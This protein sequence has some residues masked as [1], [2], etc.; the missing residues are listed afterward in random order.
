MLVQDGLVQVFPKVG[1]FV[2]RV[3]EQSV[4]DAQFLREAVE[5]ASLDDVPATPDPVVVAELR[6]ILAEQ[7]ACED[8]PEAFFHLD[9]QF[10]QGLLR[11]AHHEGT[12]PPVVAAKAH[13]DRA[14]RLGLQGHS[15]HTF[16]SQH[17]EILDSLLE[18]GA[19]SARPILRDHLR[20]VLQDIA[21]I[22]ETSPELFAPTSGPPV[23][24]NVAVWE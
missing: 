24:R 21:R 23:R 9:E 11:L 8:D 19:D 15:L 5:L 3:D 12:W 10:H 6:T 2:S 18:G 16:T 13:L 4:L 20:S 22:R 7:E 17:H 14:R 1:T